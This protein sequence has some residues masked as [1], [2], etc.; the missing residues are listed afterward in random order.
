[1]Y[2]AL[3]SLNCATLLLAGVV[4]YYKLLVAREVCTFHIGIV[5]KI[6]LGKRNT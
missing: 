6:T 1:M 4:D 2:I 5:C 3:N